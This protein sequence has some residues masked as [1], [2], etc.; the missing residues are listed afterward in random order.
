MKT[1]AG[2]WGLFVF[3]AGCASTGPQKITTTAVSI[4]TVEQELSRAQDRGETCVTLLSTLIE[5]PGP[6]FSDTYL[7]FVAALAQMDEQVQTLRD[8]ATAMD[9]R[10][11]EYLQYWLEQTS[12]IQSPELRKE[13]EARRTRLM[14]SYLD[15]NAR[16]AALKRSYAPLHAS[17]HDCA[18]FLAA[19]PRGT[20]AK[21]LAAELKKV[22]EGKKDVDAAAK[23]YR[24][25]LKVILDKLSVPASSPPPEK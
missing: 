4:T 20:E 11:D 8:R 23:D 3:A 21:A 17:L 14:E 22:L 2:V 16:G 10:R 18:R 7:K 13:A 25:G 24:D 6:A 5:S 9:V 12:G 1:I 19:D 15:L